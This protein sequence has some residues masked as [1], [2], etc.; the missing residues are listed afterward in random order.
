MPTAESPLSRNSFECSV[1]SFFVACCSIEKWCS[2]RKVKM[3]SNSWDLINIVN[4]FIDWAT[5]VFVVEFCRATVDAIVFNLIWL[6]DQ[7]WSKITGANQ[8]MPL[9]LYFC[10]F[11]FVLFFC[12]ALFASIAKNCKSKQHLRLEW[13]SF[14]AR[15]EKI[16]FRIGCH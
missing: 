15:K 1:G 4:C 9:F 13:R 6:L 11:Y 8:S 7:I 5:F 3:L 2:I 10:S 16:N 14:N 12:F